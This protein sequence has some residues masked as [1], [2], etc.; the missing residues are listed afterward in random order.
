MSRLPHGWDVVSADGETHKS[1]ASAEGLSPEMTLS[2]F[3]HRHVWPDILAVKG[4]CERTRRDYLKSLQYWVLF[5]GDPP[6]VEI[7][8]GTAAKFV[9]LLQKQ[10][11]LRPGEP[12]AQNTIFRHCANIGRLLGWTG[13][14]TAHNRHGLGLCQN[15]YW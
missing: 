15:P 10:E 11:G 8:R 5:T 7:D 13:P 6:L 1:A 2:C 3:F 12:M 14:Q 9:H 4:D